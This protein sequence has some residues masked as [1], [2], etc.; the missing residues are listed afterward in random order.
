MVSTVYVSP[1]GT[2]NNKK[3]R[4]PDYLH[5]NYSRKVVNTTC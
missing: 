4:I 2:Q 1:V 5:Q 3:E